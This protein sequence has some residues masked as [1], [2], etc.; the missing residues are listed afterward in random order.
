[1]L[2]KVETDFGFSDLRYANPTHRPSDIRPGIVE[3]DLSTELTKKP[4]IVIDSNT[5]VVFGNTSLRFQRRSNG[6]IGVDR[7]DLSG[8]I[9]D[10][11]KPF[12][13]T[14]SFKFTSP[15]KRQHFRYKGLL[16]LSR[17]QGESIDIEGWKFYVAEIN[18]GRLKLA[19]EAPD[20]AVVT[21]QEEISDYNNAPSD[22]TLVGEIVKADAPDKDKSE[23]GYLLV[24]EIKKDEVR[25]GLSFDESV[26][27][28]RKEQENKKEPKGL[29]LTRNQGD[30][31]LFLRYP[32]DPNDSK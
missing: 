26:K 4:G 9:V 28:Q 20:D 13:F 30:K 7:L 25:L 22:V 2:T 29:E 16:T 10:R 17:K 1:M 31:I 21:F 24:V 3:G 6:N 15:L 27:V 11:G 18:N 8:R 23:M 32:P 5:K 12:E 19:I 14:P